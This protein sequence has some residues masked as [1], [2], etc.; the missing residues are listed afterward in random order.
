[1]E[2]EGKHRK[3]ASRVLPPP[4]PSSLHA[5]PLFRRRRLMLIE[6]GPFP[7]F[8]SPPNPSSS[9]FQVASFPTSLLAPNILRLPYLHTIHTF[10]FSH[11]SLHFLTAPSFFQTFRRAPPPPRSSP[12]RRSWRWCPWRRPGTATDS[13][14]TTTWCTCSSP[15][16]QSTQTQGET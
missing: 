4:A 1:M 2:R 12:P 14:D 16:R 6:L 11:V 10:L 5:L 8:S 9:A 13:W 3:V 7:L 15:R